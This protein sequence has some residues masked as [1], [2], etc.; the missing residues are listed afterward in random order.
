MGNSTA[1][2]FEALQENTTGP[3]NTATGAEALFNR[4]LNVA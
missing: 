2:G 3:D 4:R 1:A